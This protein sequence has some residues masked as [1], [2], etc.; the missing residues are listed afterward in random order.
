MYIIIHSKVGE[1]LIL[2]KRRDD[3]GLN[4][5]AKMISF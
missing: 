1:N 3:N 5:T 4:L 2:T